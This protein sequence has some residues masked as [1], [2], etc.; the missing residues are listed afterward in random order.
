MYR[1]REAPAIRLPPST[2]RPTTLLPSTPLRE[3]GLRLDGNEATIWPR[4][5]RIRRRQ[6]RRAYQAVC[7]SCTPILAR[8]RSCRCRSRRRCVPGMLVHELVGRRLAGKPTFVVR[9]IESPDGQ[10]HRRG[11]DGEVQGDCKGDCIVPGRRGGGGAGAD[12]HG[13]FTLLSSNGRGRPTRL[14][15]RLNG[16]NSTAAAPSKIV[17]RKTNPGTRTNSRVLTFCCWVGWGWRG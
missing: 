1:L 15:W 9:R 2:P 13:R 14:I 7:P 11:Q 5:R 16:S 8:V 12:H 6:G 4:R 10:S 3:F 17:E